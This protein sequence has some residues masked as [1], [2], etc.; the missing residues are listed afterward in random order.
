MVNYSDY[1][2][3]GNA[4]FLLRDTLI[5]PYQLIIG[6]AGMTSNL[7][8]I[9]LFLLPK[10]KKNSFRRNVL[11][12]TTCECF[13][14]IFD[15]IM[16][17]LRILGLNSG[18]QYSYIGCSIGFSIIAFTSIAV[19]MM[20]L[21]ISLDRFACILIPVW[22][23]KSKSGG[24]LK[25]LN[26][27]GVV[28]G[29]LFAVCSFFVREGEG[30]IRVCSIYFVFGFKFYKVMTVTATVLTST[31]IFFYCIVLG[32][33]QAKRFLNR[34]KHPSTNFS[35]KVN[36][37]IIFIVMFQCILGVMPAMLLNNTIMRMLGP[38]SYHIT[39]FVTSVAHL[40]GIL[41]LWM[42][43]AFNE[44]MRKAFLNALG[45]V[46]CKKKTSVAPITLQMTW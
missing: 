45:C 32:S 19:P 1:P 22:Y 18:D 16:P 9:A 15:F 13:V 35:G 11:F 10:T 6:S 12:L 46:K 4:S 20:L 38:S 17:T 36:Q 27:F 41:N 30:E 33:L 29:L 23:F 2:L 31:S 26:V 34:N 37:Q 39:P 44:H 24:L 5:N 25:Y 28:A 14:C 3:I 43:L 8:I 40:D 7:I 21:C 42:Y